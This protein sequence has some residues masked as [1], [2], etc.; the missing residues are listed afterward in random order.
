MP[1]ARYLR[2]AL[3]LVLLSALGSGGYML[4]EG[5]GLLD[6]LYM[7]VISVTTVGYSEVHPL[8]PA[9]RIFTIVLVIAGVGLFFYAIGDIA[10]AFLEG[11]IKGFMEKRRMEKAIAKLSN[12]FVVCG[13][14][15]IGRIISRQIADHGIPVVI[16]ENDP[17]VIPEVTSE[18]FLY[19]EGDATLD[20]TLERA[21]VKKARGVV[22]VLRSDAD[23]VY[24]TLTARS[25]NPG[26]MIESRASDLS[27]EK[28]MIQA[29]AD[30]VISPYE[31]G[32]RRMALA[33]LK[34]S[35]TQ[36]L[37]LAVHTPSFDLRVEQLP[38]EEGCVLDGKSLMES[39]IR[40]ETGANILAV[41]QMTDQMIMGPDPGYVIRSGDVLIALGDSGALLALRKMTSP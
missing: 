35:V 24:I 37:D 15:R 1:G 41:Q 14:G 40:K 12:H 19:I 32:A 29:G 30:K 38:V 33:I 5:W 26:L 8:S 16:V 20:E 10:G 2:I 28:K 39:N 6:A 7:T 23:N 25:L 36:F 11:H 22:C 18:G 21:G 27:S 17:E 3:L 9:G 31:V 4:I 34:P 13:F